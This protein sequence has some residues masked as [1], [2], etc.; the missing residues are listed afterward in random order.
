MSIHKIIQNTDLELHDL[1][2]LVSAYKQTLLVPGLKDRDDS[3][4]RIVAH[5]IFEIGQTGIE[6]PA[7]ISKLAIKSARWG[8]SAGRVSRLNG[9]PRAALGEE[10][11]PPGLALGGPP[12]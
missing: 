6:D 3:I 5:K 2:R 7:E 9:W 4:T 10:P 1:Q 11:G 8:S 12:S